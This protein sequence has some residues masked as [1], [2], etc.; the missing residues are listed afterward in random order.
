M[1]PPPQLMA[2]IPRRVLGH[3]LDCDSS[4][5]PLFGVQLTRETEAFAARNLPTHTLMQRAGVA[6]TRLALALH[7]HATACWVLAGPGNNGGDGLEFALH[8]HQLGRRVHVTL[9]ADARR[10]PRD[11]ATALA[12]AVATGVPVSD[13]APAYADD[14]NT[15]IIDALLGLGANRAPSAEISAWIERANTSPA[16]VLAVDLPSGLNADTGMAY[17]PCIRATATL[18]LLSLKPGLFTAHGRDQSG[19]VWFDDLGLQHSV[20]PSAWLQTGSSAGLPPRHHAQHKGSFGTVVV[21]RGASSMAGAATL[22]ARAALSAGAGR[23]YLASLD[24]QPA[25]PFWPELMHCPPTAEVVALWETITVCGCGGGDAI[26]TLLPR[27]LSV[28]ANLVLDADALNVVA[29]DESLQTLLRRRAAAG[30]RT[31][32]TPH[33]LEAARLLQTTTGDVQR[34][35]LSAAQS[36][37]EQFQCTTVLKGSGTVITDP[38]ERPT[39]NGSGDARL[40]TPGAGDVLAGWIGAIWAQGPSPIDAAALATAAHGAAVGRHPQQRILR[41]SDLLAA[42]QGHSARQGCPISA[43]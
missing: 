18:S 24:P 8:W 2:S 1:T 17:T 6:L 25:D 3:S 23:V 43:A 15:L 30:R 9:V 20:A 38:G 37:A 27:L 35:R 12:R 31:V 40:A 28:A 14:P 13:Q 33:P 21:V 26:R 41:A 32:L 42:A 4:R 19:G 5:W 34:D 10:L 36:L 16:P 39:I 7:P 11:A 29:N 22:A